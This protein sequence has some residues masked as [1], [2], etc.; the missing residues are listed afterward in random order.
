MNTHNN[1]V[2]IVKGEK[3]SLKWHILGMVKECAMKEKNRKEREKKK[4][5]KWKRR[6]RREGKGLERREKKK[7]KFKDLENQ[8]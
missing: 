4:G 7:K 2:A 8:T 3:A 1:R 6:K 5:K